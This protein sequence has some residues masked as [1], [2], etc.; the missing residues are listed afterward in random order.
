[1]TTSSLS[2][3]YLLHEQTNPEP[4]TVTLF[5]PT[6]SVS[7]SVALIQLYHYSPAL[8]VSDSAALIQLYH[9]SPTLSVS[10]SVALIH[11]YHYSPTLSVSYSIA[12]IQPYHYPYTDNASLDRTQYKH[13]STHN[14]VLIIYSL[15][16][17]EY[18]THTSQTYISHCLTH[19]TP[20][21][22]MN[23]QPY[24]VS[25]P[26]PV[27]SK[28]YQDHTLCIL[29]SISESSADMY[30]PLHTHYFDLPV[31][32]SNAGMQ[33]HLTHT[34]CTHLTVPH[35]VST[36]YPVHSILDSSSDRRYNLSSNSPTLSVSDS[37]ALFQ[38]YHYH[39]IDKSSLDR[40]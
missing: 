11:L 27:H 33:H 5:S 14:N 30:V 37:V 19:F 24:L 2:H 1:M 28:H 17:T 6:L 25:I 32:D 26:H 18:I 8:S 9:Y 31:S 4:I 7:D 35:Q 40:L 29:H 12:L 13:R 20:G 15:R 36:S 10:Y 23:S 16:S 21:H 39:D 3:C 38:L 34:L 22:N